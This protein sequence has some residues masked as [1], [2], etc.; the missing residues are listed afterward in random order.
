MSRTQG[1]WG[2]KY[3][4]ADDSA[5][6]RARSRVVEED[7]APVANSSRQNVAP[8]TNARDESKLTV[9]SPA[10]GGSLRHRHDSRYSDATAGKVS[11]RRTIAPRL[12]FAR[13]AGGAHQVI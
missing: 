9:R 1:I 13:N 5:A 2:K 10:C 7:E 11:T 6:E 3:P 8:I 12:A 4:L